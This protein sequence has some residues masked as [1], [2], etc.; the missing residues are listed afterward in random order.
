MGMIGKTELAIYTISVNISI[1]LFLVC[2]DVCAFFS[3][4]ESH[5]LFCSKFQIAVL[6]VSI[7]IKLSLAIFIGIH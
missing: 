3:P 7:C 5:F 4:F 6:L 1:F 2:S